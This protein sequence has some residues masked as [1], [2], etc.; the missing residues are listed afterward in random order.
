MQSILILVFRSG[1][2]TK[3]PCMQIASS[4]HIRQ[5][6]IQ[7]PILPPFVTGYRAG[8]IG[9]PDS[10]LSRAFTYAY[11]HSMFTATSSRVLRTTT[12]HCNFCG[13]RLQPAVSTTRRLLSSQAAPSSS[14]G[15]HLP[16]WQITNRSQ[17]AAFSSILQHDSMFGVGLSRLSRGQRS[18]ATIIEVPTAAED[19]LPEPV[20][21]PGQGDADTTLKVTPAAEKVSML[22]PLV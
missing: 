7:L 21:K 5:L 10:V 11:I 6:S 17:R 14:A 19:D 15:R 8:K 9:L 16:R 20:L 3:S 22:K 12:G 4:C 2:T 1:I 13:S 18:Y